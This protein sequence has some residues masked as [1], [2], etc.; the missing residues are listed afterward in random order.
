MTT[1]PSFVA[2]HFCFFRSLGV[3]ISKV[4]SLTL[5]DLDL[6]EY[7]LLLRIGKKENK[8]KR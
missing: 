3:H 4:R 8:D 7:N 1:F 5:D 6:E 2:V